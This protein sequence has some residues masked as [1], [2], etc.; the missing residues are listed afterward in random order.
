MVVDL[1]DFDVRF[2]QGFLFSPPRA[3][4]ADAL[5]PSTDPPEGAPP[6]GDDDASAARARARAELA[7]AAAALKPK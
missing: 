1:I 2:G 3:V 6:T 4:R 5:G 7:L